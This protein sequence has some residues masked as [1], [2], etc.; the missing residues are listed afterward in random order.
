MISVSWLRGNSTSR[1]TNVRR[2]PSVA[3]SV[4][5]LIVA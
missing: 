3:T 1:S 4:S 2:R 5:L